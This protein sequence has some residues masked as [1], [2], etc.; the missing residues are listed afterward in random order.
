MGIV[1]SPNGVVVIGYFYLF[2]IFFFPLEMGFMPLLEWSDAHLF[3]V[4]DG[5]T[6]RS[7]DGSTGI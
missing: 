6:L 4:R 7:N 1:A 3:H 2:S 5:R